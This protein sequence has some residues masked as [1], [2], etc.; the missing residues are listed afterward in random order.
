MTILKLV[1]QAPSPLTR[2]KK[3]LFGPHLFLAAPFR[4]LGRHNFNGRAAVSH[5][6]IH[7]PKELHLGLRSTP[8]MVSGVDD[9]R[10]E[11]KVLTQQLQAVKYLLTAPDDN[12]LNFF[13]R[14]FT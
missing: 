2:D 4:M 8:V 3:N 14:W 5:T 6:C 7:A 13:S 1:S 9:E 12:T 10:N 11:L